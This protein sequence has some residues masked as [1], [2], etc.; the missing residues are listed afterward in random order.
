M[1]SRKR[2]RRSRKSAVALMMV[3]GG[4]AAAAPFVGDPASAQNPNVS[5]PATSPGMIGPVLKSPTGVA[6]PNSFPSSTIPR[7]VIPCSTKPP[8][9][10]VI[11][12]DATKKK[13]AIP[14]D[15]TKR[16][17]KVAIPCS[18]AKGGGKAAI[19]CSGTK[20]GSKAAIP[21]SYAKGGG[22]ARHSLST[23]SE[24]DPRDHEI[25]VPAQSDEEGRRDKSLPTQGERCD[26]HSKI[27]RA[28]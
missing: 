24:K 7:A 12:C 18:Y 27:R 9:A 11:P 21:C 23:L 5:N 19:P 1:S 15:T 25:A 10:T 6:A 13:L 28:S 20:G 4:L 2:G 16:G 3:T 8:G 26:C 17:G 14:C 22:K